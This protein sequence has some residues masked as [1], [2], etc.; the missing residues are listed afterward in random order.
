MHD[1]ETEEQLSKNFKRPLHTFVDTPAIVVE[2]DTDFT[3]NCGHCDEEHKSD[4]VIYFPSI[5][6][7]YHIASKLVKLL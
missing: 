7:K 5:E 3:F 2:T 4:I 6:K 1:F